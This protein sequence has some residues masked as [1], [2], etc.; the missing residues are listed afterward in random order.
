MSDKDTVAQIL[1]VDDNPANLD[2]LEQVLRAKGYRIRSALTGPLALES[3]KAVQPDLVILDI[4]MPGMDGFE[5]CRL[6]KQED[7]LKDIP[8]IFISALDNVPDKVKA[9]KVGGADY[10]T[11]PFH[12]EEIIARVDYQVQLRLLR[13]QLAEQVSGIRL[14]AEA[15]R[16]QT[17]EF[18]NKLHVILGLIRLEEF[19]R[20]SSYITG[21]TGR[22]Q[23]EVGQVVPRVKDPM[24]AGFLLARSSAAREQ[25]ITM[26]L[27]EASQ[28]PLCASESVAHDLVTILG[29][30]MENAVEAI[31]DSTRREIHVD[32]QHDSDRLTIEV[33]DTGPGI[34]AD[35]R[36]RLFE[37]GFSTK[38]VDR[39]F[40]LYHVFQ[41]VTA[42][43][44]RLV[45]ADRE[46]G[47]TVFR[48]SI[49]YPEKVPE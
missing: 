43:G 10:V 26:L 49:H 14:Y 44:G 18:M 42:L 34:A 32:L 45:A 3:A 29:N 5:V 23:D 16:A 28:V 24:I 17:H 21:L 35:C 4:S 48:A 47:G 13:Q 2:L 15:L 41:R 33:A 46:G 36:E 30:L 31:G 8:I 37:R 19:D 39:G 22:L 38:G 11:K 25:N 7:R 6:M 9:F 20:L 12:A 27:S 1:L 40:G